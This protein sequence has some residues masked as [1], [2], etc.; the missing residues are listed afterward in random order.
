MKKIKLKKNKKEKSN[1][2]LSRHL[3]DIYYQEAKRKGGSLITALDELYING[4]VYSVKE[5]TISV[6]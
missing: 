6:P 2:W 3:N 4:K 5:K 1:K